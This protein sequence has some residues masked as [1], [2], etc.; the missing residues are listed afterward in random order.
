MIVILFITCILI[1]FWKILLVTTFIAFSSYKPEY[2]VEKEN[3]RYVANVNYYVK[4][5]EVKVD[6]FDYI[7]CFLVGNKIKICED[8]GDGLY[9]P[10]K[11]EHNN[12][13]LIKSTYYD[14]N[15]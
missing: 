9:D 15:K 8:Y 4:K 10:F 2:V 12:E 13:K 3:K 14:N 7:N 11:K 1:L 6:Y 5:F